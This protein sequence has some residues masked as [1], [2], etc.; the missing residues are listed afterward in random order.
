VEVLLLL[1]LGMFG[2][3]DLRAKLKF[4]GFRRVYGK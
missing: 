1:M 4:N 3:K 2:R